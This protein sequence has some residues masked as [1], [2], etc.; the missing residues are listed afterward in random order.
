MNFNQYLGKYVCGNLSEMDYPELA[1]T[2]LL[3]GFDSK[4]LGI[5]AAMNRTDEISELRKYLKWT[6]EELNIEI[7]TKREAALLYTSGIINEI[8]EEKKEIIKGVS[9]IKNDALFSYDFF[10]ESDKYCY[11]SIGFENIHGLFVEYYDSLDE[12][13]VDKKHI[14]DT[15]NEILSEL[16]KWKSRLK[17][18]V[19]HRI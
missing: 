1:V 19:Q 13:N 14:E 11:D 16:K 8:L 4:Y 18:V 12:L 2:G 9:E 10:S 3:E 5:L 6:I 7:P 17:N 15:K